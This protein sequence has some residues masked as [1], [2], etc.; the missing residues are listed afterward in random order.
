MSQILASHTLYNLTDRVQCLHANGKNYRFEA[1][2]PGS[3]GKVAMTAG[4]AKSFMAVHSKLLTDDLSKVP[5]QPKKA[6]AIDADTVASLLSVS[7]L[8]GAI[9]YLS[10]GKLA[11]AD[12]KTH[13]EAELRGFLVNLALT[14]DAGIPVKVEDKG[15]EKGKK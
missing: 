5:G 8:I 10:S 15:T 13:S 4:E 7:E 6:G 14:G 2:T 3:V 9:R 12:L 11:S 1:T